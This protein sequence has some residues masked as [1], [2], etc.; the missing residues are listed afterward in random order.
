MV[1]DHIVEANKIQIA[2]VEVPKNVFNGNTIIFIVA[3]YK[4]L[5]VKAF[6]LN[7]G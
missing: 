6:W 1:V 4:V 3:A 7:D 5:A 2:F